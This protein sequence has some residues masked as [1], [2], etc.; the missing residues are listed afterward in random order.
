[1]GFSYSSLGLS[2]GLSVYEDMVRRQK[3]KEI[4]G[5]KDRELVYSFL[6]TYVKIYFRII[7]PKL[8]IGTI[9]M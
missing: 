4:S 1:M 6:Q 2:V 7:L 9:N 8:L 5:E 3:G